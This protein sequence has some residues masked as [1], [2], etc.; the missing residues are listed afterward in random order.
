MLAIAQMDQPWRDDDRRIG[1]GGRFD[2][3]R[4]AQ[5][6]CTDCSESTITWR[7]SRMTP[8]DRRK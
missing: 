6:F 2:L 4:C 3:D 5:P 1:T 8:S 7:G